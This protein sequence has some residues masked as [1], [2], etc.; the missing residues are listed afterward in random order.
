MAA[1]VICAEF[2]LRAEG[3]V[4]RRGSFSLAAA[5]SEVLAERPSPCVLGIRGARALH[6]CHG[7]V[8]LTLG[9]ECRCILDCRH[10]IKKFILILNLTVSNPK[11]FN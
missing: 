1:A 8:E 6:Q 10:R 9:A 7:I 4:D 11:S 3:S 2:I 5:L